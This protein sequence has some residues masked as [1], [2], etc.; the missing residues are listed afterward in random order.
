MQEFEKRYATYVRNIGRLVLNKADE[1]DAEMVRHPS[2]NQC[3]CQALGS[4]CWSNMDAASRFL[5]NQ[6]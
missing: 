1:A 4:R 6:N 5:S 3:S 2:G